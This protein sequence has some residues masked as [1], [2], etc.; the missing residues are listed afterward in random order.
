MNIY[1]N[2][3][4]IN[5]KLKH[6]II[7]LFLNNFIFEWDTIALFKPD[8]M[9]EK[10]KEKTHGKNIMILFQTD[11]CQMSILRLKAPCYF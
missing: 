11:Y 10:E 6:I 2:F 9:L 8:Y 3:Y 4:K 5:R 7:K 1:N